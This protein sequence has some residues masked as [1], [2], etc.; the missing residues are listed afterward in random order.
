MDVEMSSA[1]TT[2]MSGGGNY[3]YWARMPME[4]ITLQVRAKIVKIRSLLDA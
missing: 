2:G 3:L 1:R 4:T